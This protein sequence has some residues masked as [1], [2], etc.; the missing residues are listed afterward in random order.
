MKVVNLFGG[1]N[2]G[3]ST[4]AAGVYHKMKCDGYEVEI[5][6]EYAKE[7]VYEQRANIMDDQ[8]YIFAKQYRRVSRLRGQ[9]DYVIVDSPVLMSCAYIL[10]GYYE[11]LEPLVV[12]AFKSF[13]NYNFI[14]ERPSEEEY[15]QA[16]RVQT[17]EEAQEKDRRIETLLNKY[18]EPYT[19]I[20]S[21]NENCIQLICDLIV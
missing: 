7:M 6:T 2:T 1:P 19:P 18:S 17:F 13:D 15:K 14:L 10:E 5:V 9:V 20:N 12:E 11:N 21:R 16:N 4:L 3:K 8:L